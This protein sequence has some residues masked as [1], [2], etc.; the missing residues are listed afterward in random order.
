MPVLLTHLASQFFSVSGL[1]WMFRMRILMCFGIAMV[2]ILSPFDIIPESVFGLIGIIDDVFVLLLFAV[3]ISIAYRRF[4]A[5][6][7]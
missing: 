5:G 2:Y 4:L 3:Y 1:I 6:N 7:G